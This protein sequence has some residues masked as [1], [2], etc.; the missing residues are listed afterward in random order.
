MCVF[1]VGG[2]A[3]LFVSLFFWWMTWQVSQDSST[4]FF[5]NSEDIAKKKR[6]IFGSVLKQKSDPQGKSEL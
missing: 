4:Y 1:F 2:W 5:H 3:F 6:G